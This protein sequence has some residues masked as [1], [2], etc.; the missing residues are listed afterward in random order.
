MARGAEAKI[1]GTRL[2][3]TVSV[4]TASGTL[5]VPLTPIVKPCIVRAYL[6]PR[7]RAGSWHVLRSLVV[8]VL[9]V[10]AIVFFA[11]PSIGNFD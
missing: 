6:R 3:T 10:V 11:R 9:L 1:T 7:S 5:H 8:R 4:R 2:V